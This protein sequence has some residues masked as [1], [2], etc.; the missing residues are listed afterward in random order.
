MRITI[1]G[2][3]RHKPA[4][5]LADRVKCRECGKQGS[6]D[7]EDCPAKMIYDELDETSK[8]T[9]WAEYA[10]ICE[11]RRE[12]IIQAIDRQRQGKQ[13]RRN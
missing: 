10:A 7:C 6:A 9:Y 8:K 2:P 11:N 1:G 5:Q 13:K 12:K 3:P 4:Y